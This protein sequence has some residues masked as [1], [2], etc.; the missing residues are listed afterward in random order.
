MSSLFSV[1]NICFSDEISDHIL[2][3]QSSELLVSVA[4]EETET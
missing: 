1:K 4:D 3:S 2:V